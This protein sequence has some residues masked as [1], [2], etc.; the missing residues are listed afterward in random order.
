V[1]ARVGVAIELLSTGSD[2]TMTDGDVMAGDVGEVTDCWRFDGEPAAEATPATPISTTT[3][4]PTH[5]TICLTR[6]SARNR[7]H[8]EWPD[9]TEPPIDDSEELVRAAQGIYAPPCRRSPE[10]Q[11][12]Q[13]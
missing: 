8:T 11:W 7:A 1:A 9:D 6:D 3:A 4:T 10:L 5:V 12:A 2:E 13:T